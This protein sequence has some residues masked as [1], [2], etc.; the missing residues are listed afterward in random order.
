MEKLVTDFS[1]NMPASFDLMDNFTLLSQKIHHRMNL[2][3]LSET[4][5]VKCAYNKLC[6]FLKP[7]DSNHTFFR[8]LLDLEGSLK[9]QLHW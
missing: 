6:G 4:S 5:I 2:R 9:K 1:Q 8:P 7:C 3:I